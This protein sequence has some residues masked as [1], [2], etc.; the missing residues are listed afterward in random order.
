[1]N[2][3]HASIADASGIGLSLLCMA[4]CFILPVLTILAPALL[5]SLSGWLFTGESAHFLFVLVA[6]PITVAAFVWGARISRAGWRTISAAGAG[7]LLMLLGATHLF[8]ETGETVL[9]LAGV[10]ILA[11]AHFVNWRT[12]ARMGH[13]HEDECVIC[14]D[15]AHDAPVDPLPEGNSHLHTLA[16]GHAHDQHDAGAANDG[17]PSASVA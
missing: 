6:A 12:R 17:K 16:D 2:D 9:T 4:H 1:M 13:D 11:A 5:P 8:G 7:L 14:E 15:H 3:R 10:S